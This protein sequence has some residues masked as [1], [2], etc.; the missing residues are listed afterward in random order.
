MALKP[1][2]KK[3]GA[4]IQAGITG[5]L[6]GHSFESVLSK[7]IDGCGRG[8]CAPSVKKEGHLYVGDPAILLVSY[9][10]QHL[11]LKRVDSVKAYWLGGRATSG[12][13]DAVPGI[14]AD[15]LKGSKSDVLIEVVNKGKTKRIGVSVKSCSKRAATN[16][17]LY[18]TTASGLCKLFRKNKIPVSK[19]FEIGLKRFCGDIGHRPLDSLG[20]KLKKR[21]SHPERWF[22]EELP[23]KS[24]AAITKVFTKYQNEITRA[25]LQ[26]AYDNDPF[27]P[28]YVLHQRSRRTSRK[29]NSHR[30][31]SYE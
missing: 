28:Q 11:R 19:H 26:H 12:E 13:G 5:R 29:K 7:T 24:K 22:F 20:A 1:R 2:D 8:I 9:I 16:A 3:H 10:L 21:K 23:K 30:S 6:K 14:S 15:R 27:P 18:C 17:Q 31:F 25:L 4:Q